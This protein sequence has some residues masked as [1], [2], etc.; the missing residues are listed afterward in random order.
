M[1]GQLEGEGRSAGGG[2]EV[3][4]RG[5][6]GQLEGEGRSA[7]GGG[8]EPAKLLGHSVSLLNTADVK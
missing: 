6:G 3:S 5:R 7:G 1:V 2:G 8:E 4:W